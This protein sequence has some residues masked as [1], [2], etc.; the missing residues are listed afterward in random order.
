MEKQ[1]TTIPMSEDELHAVVEVV[2]PY[3]KACKPQSSHHDVLF[4]CNMYRDFHG[5]EALRSLSRYVLVNVERGE[6]G[7]VIM[8]TVM[9][10]LFG[11]GECFRP[12]S[13]NW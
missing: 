2:F 6:E 11:K 3:V 7:A 1:P 4:S 10:D 12:R 5:D 8:A 9:H 13:H